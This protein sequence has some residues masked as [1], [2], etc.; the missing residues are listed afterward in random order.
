MRFASKHAACTPD[1]NNICVPML[2][3]EE[4]NFFD[5]LIEI[6]FFTNDNGLYTT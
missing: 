3:E 6:Y 4:E 2:T 5:A 1:S